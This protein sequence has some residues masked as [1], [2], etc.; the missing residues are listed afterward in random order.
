MIVTPESALGAALLP[1]LWVAAVAA[2]SLA[3]VAA[4]TPRLSVLSPI[5]STVG[6]ASALALGCDLLVSQASLSGSAVH[7]L[8]LSTVLVHL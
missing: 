1:A 8:G 3:A 2:L 4:C 6:A 5:L 7:V